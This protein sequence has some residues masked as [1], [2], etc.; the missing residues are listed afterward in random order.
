MQGIISEHVSSVILISAY[1]NFSAQ[2]WVNIVLK[3]QRGS[4][5]KIMKPNMRSSN[6]IT[7]I[8]LDNLYNSAFWKYLYGKIGV[9]I[10]QVKNLIVLTL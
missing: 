9:F 8:S 5:V 1:L 10:F 6:L 7:G 3:H 4:L 2:Y